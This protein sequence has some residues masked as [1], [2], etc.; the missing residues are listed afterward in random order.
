[1]RN[2]LHCDMNNFYASVECMLNPE[3]KNYPVAVCGSV[4]DRHGIVLAKNYKAKS[5]GVQTGDAVWEAKQKCENIVIVPPH[6]DEY[7]K[8]SKLARSIY[9]RYTDLVEP[10][11]M[12]EC[13][14]DITGSTSLFGDANKIAEDIRDATKRELGLTISI[15]VSFNKVFSKLGSDMKKPDAIT[16]IPYDNFK[17]KIWGLPASDMIG[18]GRATAKKLKSRCIYTI[19]DLAN[20]DPVS[21]KYML[22]INGVKLWRFANGFDNSPVMPNEYNAPIKSIG[23]GIT[24]VEDL[25]QNS[26]VFKVILEMTQNISKKLKSNSLLATGIGVTVRDNRLHSKNYSR[27][28]RYASHSAKEIAEEAYKLFEEKHIWFCD[29]RSITVTALNLIPDSIP[30]QLDLFG[31]EEQREKNEKIENAISDIRRRFGQESITYACL[32]GN[33]KMPKN[34]SVDITMPTGVFA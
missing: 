25:T 9:D 28:M 31:D 27:K 1:M 10:F 19:G 16:E 15:G 14:L 2:I 3:L 13:W 17:E 34:K 29:I 5:F 26:D 22:G 23:H 21:L 33:N 11:G 8:F 12:D 4:E 18:V 7:L 32:L 6:Y 30:Q 20:Y 24:C